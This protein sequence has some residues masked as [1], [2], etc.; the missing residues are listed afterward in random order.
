MEVASYSREGME[1]LLHVYFVKV[2]AFK[3]VISFGNKSSRWPTDTR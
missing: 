3:S 1:D 2:S